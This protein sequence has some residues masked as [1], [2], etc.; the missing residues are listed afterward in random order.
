MANAR[1]RALNR[2]ARGI[3]S[4]TTHIIAWKP[5]KLTSA[6]AFGMPLRGESMCLPV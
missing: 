3:A 5:G 1:L 6:A 4:K 2:A